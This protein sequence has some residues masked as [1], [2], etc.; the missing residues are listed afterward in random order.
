MES[1]RFKQMQRKYAELTVKIGLNLQPGQRLIILAPLEAVDLVRDV[2]EIAYQMGCR[3]V[4]VM[5]GDEQ[6]TL[7]RFQSAPRDS[8][9]EY[10]TW[11]IDGVL[12][13]LDRGDALLS[14]AGSDPDL[15]KG[16][17]PE[18]MAIVNQNAQKL[19]MPISA[20]V[21]EN[22]INWAI[23]AVPTESWARKVFPESA[24]TQAVS[25]LWDAIFN[26]C[27]LNE[28]DPIAAWR[29]HIDQLAQRSDYLNAKHYDALH[30]T[31]PGTDL[32]IGLPDGHLWV[33]GAT[34]SKKG[35][36]F[37][38]NLPTEEV[39][40]LPHKDRT[41]GVV[42]ASKPLSYAGSLIQDF[43]LTFDHGKV[44]DWSAKK[45]EAALRQLIGTD[46]NAGRLGEVSLV[47][48]RS[49]ISQSG[50]IFYNTLFDENAADH[51][52]LGRA[53]KFTLHNGPA[54]SDEEFAQAGG[55]SS[56]VHVDFMIGSAQT[57]VDGLTRAGVTEPIMRNG[58]W[59]FQV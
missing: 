1:D 10:S 36:P 38:A 37:T 30:F 26:V 45:G 58:E 39:F 7:I 42:T 50:L 46:E 4:N 29:Q 21:S 27:R 13:F 6:L 25:Q 28:P 59:A 56:L 18:L 32:T 49:P 31:A 17:D 41:Q 22:S 23:V 16:Q 54:M 2:T 35:I 55:N 34:R 12:Q 14:I 9:G 48:D 15:L 8:F 53:L 33:S 19:N 24:L 3:L 44:V 57:N 52:A 43:R 51:I 20:H 11:S 5:W 47:P 40:T